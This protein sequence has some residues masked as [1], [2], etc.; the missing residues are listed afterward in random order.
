MVRREAEMWFR[1]AER[2]LGKAVNDLATGDWDSAAFW[3]QQ[4]AE[5]ALNAVLLNAG[6]AHRGNELLG[7]AEA[8]RAELGVDV[9]EIVDDLRELTVHYTISRYPNAANAVL[10]ELYDERRARDLVERARRVLE[11]SRRYLR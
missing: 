8:I 2:D 5:K 6:V 9:S 7:I 10:Y 4:A 3:S 1:Q 11:W